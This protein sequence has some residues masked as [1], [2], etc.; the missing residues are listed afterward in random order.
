M[1]LRLMVAEATMPELSRARKAKT[2]FTQLIAQLV[3]N[4]LKNYFI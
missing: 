1:F 3:G 4:R 2:L